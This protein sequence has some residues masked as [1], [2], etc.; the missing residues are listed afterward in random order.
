MKNTE[1][2]RGQG[3]RWPLKR[4]TKQNKKPSRN[5]HVLGKVRLYYHSNEI[6]GV[7]YSRVFRKNNTNSIHRCHRNTGF[8][9]FCNQLWSFS[10]LV[11]SCFFSFLKSEWLFCVMVYLRYVAC[12]LFFNRG[13]QLR[14]YFSLRQGYEFTVLMYLELLNLWAFR[15]ELNVL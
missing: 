1:F 5:R 13:S 6:G 12:I 9:L 4:K 2:W 10:D 15:D 8:G 14:D 3:C 11:F 7:G